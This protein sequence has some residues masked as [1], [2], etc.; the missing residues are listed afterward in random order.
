MKRR[1]SVA[2]IPSVVCAVVFL[3]QFLAGTVFAAETAAGT[4]VAYVD[5][6]VALNES[7]AGKKA[8]IELESLIKSKQSVIDEKG[9]N[10]E[11][12]KADLDKQSSVLSAEAKKSKEDEVERLVRDYQRLV[13]DSQNEVKKKEGELTGSIIKELREV[14][15]KIGQ[16][17]GYSLILE[18]VEGIILYSRKD[19][20]ITERIVKIYNDQ[21]SKKK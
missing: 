14:V 21:K 20:D 3:A 4:K 2:L 15:E 13:Q 16:D 17:D 10:I 9:K 11:K 7:D 5:L 8:K 12:M 6:R 1:S 19:L 18:N